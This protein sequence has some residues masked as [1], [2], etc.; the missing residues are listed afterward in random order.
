[1]ELA[2]K[3]TRTLAIGGMTGDV[4]VQKVTATLRALS[5]LN[6]Q[7]VKVGQAMIS[8]SQ[9]ACDQAC[10][11]LSAAGFESREAAAGANCAGTG[12]AAQCCGGGGAEAAAAGQSMRSEGGGGAIGFEPGAPKKNE[13][14]AA[15]IPGTP[16]DGAAARH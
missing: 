16:A 10:A 2:T 13:S 9:D 11:M 5:D 3:T 1:M 12:A 14:A 7:S 8:A 4:C 6:I 15:R